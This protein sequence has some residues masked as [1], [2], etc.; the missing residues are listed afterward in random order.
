MDYYAVDALDYEFIDFEPHP[1]PV[2]AFEDEEPPY[3]APIYEPALVVLPHARV[4]NEDLEF[5]DL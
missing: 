2:L 1:N 5:H 4:A 3:V